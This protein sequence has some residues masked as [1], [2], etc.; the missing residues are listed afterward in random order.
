MRKIIIEKSKKG[1]VGEQKAEM[2]ERK[3]IG[4]PDYIC[5]S[6]CEAGSRA[7]SRYYIKNFKNVLHHNIDKGLLVAGK[8][9]PKFGGGKVL[10]PF[11][12]TIAGRATARL[13][14]KIPVSK[15]LFNSAKKELDKMRYLKPSYY[16]LNVDVKEG[17]ANLKQVFK[18]V[19]ANDSSFGVGFAP[20]SKTERLC[21]DVCNFINSKEFL[22]RFPCVGEDVKVM[23]LR[24][25]DEV[26]VIS[27]IAFVDRFISS[28]GDYIENKEKIKDIIL[29]KFGINSIDINALDDYK[30][31][32]T[33]Y[34]TVTGLSAEHGDDGNT[35]RG[36]KPCGLIT[37]CREMSLEAC[38]GK[39]INHPGKLYQVLSQIIADKITKING[40]QE[41][42]VKL[43]S[44]I[45]KPLDEPQVASI[46]LISDDF[47]SVRKEAKEV[48]DDV[49]D[50]IKKIQKG[51]VEGRYRLF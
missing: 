17:A 29:K 4:H 33:I 26:K 44:E 10:E 41:V 24:D 49:L 25:K 23:V 47:G 32:S 36:N 18:K 5:D 8:S 3:G 16:K 35:G 21:L 45:G 19:A 22:K 6:V 15:I 50:N 28:M 39:N 43:M 2:V 46:N 34:L 14:K 13:D 37:P 9:R 31:E 51:I 40:V 11:K 48:A 42:C 1:A 27:A 30:D 20:L 7:L 38:A 12:V